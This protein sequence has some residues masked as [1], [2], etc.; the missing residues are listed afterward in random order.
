[1]SYCRF[2]TDDFQCDLYCYESEGGYMTHV[3][4]NRVVFKEVLPPEIDWEVDMEGYLARHNKIMS[5][6]D[7]ADRVAITLPHVGETFCDTTLE[8]FKDT[9][10]MLKDAGYRFPDYVFERIEEEMEE[11]HDNR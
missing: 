10:L 5:M 1:M 2:S 3:A 4:G 11:L 7:K 8:E 6:V 9:L